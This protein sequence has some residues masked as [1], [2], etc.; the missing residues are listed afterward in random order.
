MR[1]S[2]FLILLSCLVFGQNK[3]IDSLKMIVKKSKDDTLKVDNLNIIS[4]SF[5]DKNW[6]SARVYTMSSY[7]LAKKLG[8]KRGMFYNL[9]NLGV[10]E[11]VGGNFNKSLEY[12]NEARKFLPQIKEKKRIANYYYNLGNLYLG[13]GKDEDAIKSYNSAIVKYKEINKLNSISGINGN[14]SLIYTKR[15]DY[16]KANELLFSNIQYFSSKNDDKNLASAYNNVGN[17]YSSLKEFK[18]ALE[19]YK[20]GELHSNKANHLYLMA[21]SNL[22][23]GVAYGEL[24]NIKLSEDYLLKSKELYTQASYPI[25][26][27][28]VNMNLCNLYLRK[29]QYQK[30]NYIADV[31]LVNKELLKSEPDFINSHLM[32]GKSLFYL[33]QYKQALP[34]LEISYKKAKET[35]NNVLITNIIPFLINS[36][37][38]SNNDKQGE[39][40]FKEYDSLSK[41]KNVN[42]N[43]QI[44]FKLDTQFRTAEKETQ[45][46]VQEKQINVEKTNRNIAISGIGF[47]LLLSGGGFWF[48][49][50]RQKQK[51]LQNQNTLLGLQQNLNAMELQSLNKQL[52]PHEIKNLLASISPE[53]QEKAP[54]SYRKM[55]KLFNITKA[56]LNSHSLT[57]NIE[58]QIQQTEDFL[59]LEKN[60]LSV[61]LEYSIENNLV[62][63]DL[64]IP[65]LMLKNLVENAIKHGIKGKE[66]GGMI[67]IELFEKNNFIYIMVDD[68]G[69]GRKNA[70]SLDSGIGTSTYQ[71]LFATLNNK[72]KDNATF[73]ITDKEQG[74]KVEVRIPK[75]YKYN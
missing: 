23:I 19:Y 35:K 26:V 52:D 32:K 72:N 66:N 8:D 51:E 70:I 30:A 50:N 17:N 63:K 37:F 4:G 6:D 55:L 14:L 67:K 33:Q 22:N 38:R 1:K 25:G 61:P 60:M 18:K 46:K 31:I 15:S 13:Y 54:E 68:T 20:L 58:I 71:K 21:L 42:E 45:I 11:D 12:Y 44:F 10:Y 53:I 64:Q 49:K 16:K 34:L 47:L 62:Q 27:Q 75:D 74:T 39:I 56:S 29:K 2:L 3:K 9:I 36:K 5:W 69:R 48:F 41:L 7:N 65:R 28:K 40:L 24:K 57:E 73:E 43:K 59:S